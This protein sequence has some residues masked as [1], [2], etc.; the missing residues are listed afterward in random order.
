MPNSFYGKK[1]KDGILVSCFVVLKKAKGRPKSNTRS[2]MI[3][4]VTRS[5]SKR[6]QTFEMFLSEHRNEKTVANA[7]HLSGN[8][9]GSSFD[10]HYFV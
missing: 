4:L 10:V 9:R 3:R 1:E 8:A 7:N 6:K 5:N 2:V